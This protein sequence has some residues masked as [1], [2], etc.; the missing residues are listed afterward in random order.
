MK[1]MAFKNIKD[2]LNRDE[3]KGVMAGTG[4]VQTCINCCNTA[5]NTT[6]Y[7]SN[8]YSACVRNICSQCFANFSSDPRGC[9]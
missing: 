3:M 9:Y 8:D 6:C 1:S 5:A 4:N 2:I 7:Y